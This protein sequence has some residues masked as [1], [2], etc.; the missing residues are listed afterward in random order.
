MPRMTRR[1]R[2]RRRNVVAT[3][4]F[5]AT[6]AVALGLGAPWPVAVSGAWGVAALLI[7]LAIW[8]RILR[9]DAEQTK[10]NARDEDFSRVSGD[11]VLL[12]TSLASL[13]AIFYLVDEAGHRDGA[14]KIALAVQAVTVVVLSWLLVQTVYTVRYGDL[15]YGDPIGGIDFNDD[16]PPDYHDF[17]YLAFTI[18]MTYQVSDTTLRT[19]AVRRTAIRQALVSFVFVTVI[20]AVT[21]NVVASL[22]R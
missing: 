20:L 6:L 2:A 22:L 21:V 17:L 9:M 3:F 5:V 12:V 19:K 10:A 7:G 18:G 8:P 14:A 4:A 16:S 13:V 11:V 1:Q 15:Y